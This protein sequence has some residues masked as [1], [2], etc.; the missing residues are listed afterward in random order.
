MTMKTNTP[1][2]PLGR[3][4]TLALAVLALSACLLF[5]ASVSAQTD[6]SAVYSGMRW[7]LI[8]PHRAGRVT[9][10]AGI[11][12]QPATY[13]FGTPGG[14]LWKT[15]NAGR[16][17]QP[18]F[19]SVNV[20]SIGALALAPSNPKIIYVGT[21]ERA[22]GNGVYKSSDAGA[23]WTNVGLRETN[24]ISALIVD[25]QNPDVVIAGAI[26]PFGAGDDR[27]IFKTTDGGRNW[28]KVFFK[29]AKT[30]ILD[31]CA[32][33]NDS[34]I[35]YAATG[36][37]G[38]GPGAA[39]PNGPSAFIYRSN[40]EGSTWQLV[41]GAG[42]PAEARG[43]IGV[44][45][46]P[47]TSG[48]R[49]YAIM[50]QGFFRSDD[51]GENWQKITNDPRVLG[52]GYFS[53]VF[54][55]P[56]NADDVF[57][58]QTATYRSQDGGKTFAAFKGEPSGEDDHVMWIAPD[59]PQ[60]MIMGTDQG[61]VITFDDG[62]TW[63][64]WFNQPTGEMYHVVT[65]TAFPYRLYASQQDSGSVAVTSR[66]DFGQIT[67][68]D[69]FPSGSFESGYIAPDPTNPNYIYSI[70]WFG[71]VLR[72]D[73]VT[74]QIST[75]FVPG[76]KYRYTWETP[77]VFSPTDP[78]TLYVG[79]QHV[80]R[81]NDGAVNWTE[82]SPDLT[83]KTTEPVKKNHA[84]FDDEEDKPQ[85][86]ANGVIQTIAPSAAKAGIIW[87][88][89]ST[90]LV[91]LTRDGGK[92]WQNVTPP[93]LPE[94]AAII[95]IE[96]SPRNADTAYVIGVAI[97]DSHPYIYRTRDGGKSWQKIVTGLPDKGIA[98]VVREDPTREG[99]V[100]AGTETGAHVSYD[101]GD[102]WQTL[103]L[104]LPTVS[105]RDLQVHD[106][107][108]VA[109]T[110]GRGLWSLDNLSPL[111]NADDK[112][113]AAKVQLFAPETATRARWDSWP[114]TPLPADT[115]AGQNP[116][117]GALIDYYLQSDVAGEIT[118]DVR[119]EHGRTVRHYSSNASASNLLPA[120]APEYWFA[121]PAVLSTKAG[122][123]RFVWNLQWEHPATLP[124]GYYGKL[125][126]YTEYTVPD[127]AVTGQTPRHQPPGPYAVPGR[128]EVVLT[129]EGQT[130]RQPLIVKADPRVSASQAD[131]QA[132][133]DLA[134]Q[135]TDGMAASYTSYY[136]V[137]AL[138]AALAD[139]RKSKPDVKELG[140]AITELEKQIAELADGSSALPGFGPI[141]RDLARYLAMI[142]SGDVRPAP[143]ARENAE[144]ACM[145]LKTNLARWR[146]INSDKLPALNKLLQQNNL[147]ALV[148][149]TP[150]ADPICGQA[151]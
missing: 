84:D 78:K 10:V 137:N 29:D 51:A 64:E 3:L 28:T 65:D 41:G 146:V 17:W 113:A 19:D 48:K 8:G 22:N 103:Q 85:A 142:E 144:S 47:G 100:Y 98:R 18:I 54:V 143:S 117:D 133:L 9:A 37:V 81:T 125:L 121:P 73:R 75:V 33:P 82:I 88:G 32:D 150:P 24:A 26:G 13:Y 149:V 90:G 39:R 20:A 6:R 120:N 109:A 16:T 151:H 139:R 50:S 67:L 42:L 138:T 79:M 126:G 112:I 106:N 130:Y 76:P 27:G 101:G 89:T 34:T 96:A 77:L 135:M 129:V 23:T 46:A 74:N 91:Q 114:D 102:H 95:L 134:R 62:A 119:D 68:R 86:P 5:A 127:H 15:I 35:I 93:G 56:K 111:R 140:S 44:G 38:F 105:V 49:V 4:T 53:R 147:A 123:H 99:L 40:D 70:G 145:A 80:L 118:L 1:P 92:N 108:L 25:P 72:L 45:V 69:W 107:D 31:M 14:G 52:S 60:R 21:G 104:N 11:V 43:R 116:V 132:Q 30:A 63:T 148:A 71:T 128:Y 94:R 2:N 87:V 55:N 12:G 59:D 97:P 66:S 136:D 83:Q 122:L 124:F 57:V 61:A 110:Y 131:L 36:T 141:N 58:M 7:R 115:A